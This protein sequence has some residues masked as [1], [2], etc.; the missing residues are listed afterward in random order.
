MTAWEQ[1]TTSVSLSRDG[2]TDTTGGSG[3][4]RGW[5]GGGGVEIGTATTN[6]F[7]F[8]IICGL[9]LASVSLVKG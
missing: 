5:G 8:E 7:Q 9:S 6:Q 3:G 1:L 4:S 2:I